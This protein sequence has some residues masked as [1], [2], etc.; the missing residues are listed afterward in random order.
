VLRSY[1]GVTWSDLATERGDEILGAMCGFLSRH[2]ANPS[3]TTLAATAPEGEIA[4]ISYRVQGAGPPLVLLP[5]EL[6]PRQWGPLIPALAAHWTTIT[7]GGAHLGSVASLEERGRSGYIGVVRGLLDQLTIRARRTSGRSG[8]RLG[9]DH[10][11][12]GAPDGR[13]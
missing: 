3:L 9:R 2:D 4:G 10:A 11:R 6:S 5:L 8:L 13:R 12:I 7:L 1:A